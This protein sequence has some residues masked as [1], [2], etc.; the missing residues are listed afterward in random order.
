MTQRDADGVDEAGPVLETRVAEAAVPAQ[1]GKP[2]SLW[3]H[4]DFMLLW[5]GQTVSDVGSAVTMLALPLLAVSVL[6]ASTFQVSL[7]SILTSLAFLLIS[8]PAGVIVDQ[9]RKHGLMMWCDVARMVL[10]GSIPLAGWLWHVTLWQ[11]YLVATLAGVL[12]V[13]FDVSYQSYVPVLLDGEQLVDAN[14]K[15]GATNSFA[16]LVGPS[17]GGALVG[18]IGAAKA[19]AADA[20]SFAASA[21]SLLLIR[22]HEPKPEKRAEHV[23]FRA[24]MNE[25]LAFVV[26]HPILRKIVACTGTSNFFS[27]TVGAVDVV[28]LVR[29]LHASPSVIGALFSLAAIGGVIGGLTAGLLG[30]WIGS[31]RIIWVSVLVPSPLFL[32]MPLAR[33]GWGVLLFAVGLFAQFFLAVVYNT[34][35][36]SYRQRICPPQLL[37]RMN[38]SVRWIVWGT[39]PLGALFGGALGTW[40]GVR[41][42]IA[43]GAVGGMLSGLWVFF[44]PLRQLRDVPA[45]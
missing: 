26:K 28:F 6:K 36:V 8:L 9:V 16:G 21:I 33:P 13:F 4:R 1:R 17:V 12:S 23:T 25:G 45:E 35:Q 42:T 5:S 7:I 37:G 3:R 41:E 44:S 20:G 2:A 11:I 18:F 15:L 30:R 29:V 39:M 24:A 22:T 14:G 34:A 40:I 43:I 38:A 19:I 32:L 27:S 31:A 10:L